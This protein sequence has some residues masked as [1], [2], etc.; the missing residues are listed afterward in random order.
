MDVNARLS[1]HEND[2][3]DF[4]ELL[5]SVLAAIAIVLLVAT[6]AALMLLIK[7]AGIICFVMGIYL[8]YSSFK[9]EGWLA[10]AGLVLLVIG[11]QLWRVE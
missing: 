7:L 11:I 1:I 8:L 4:Y 9:Y 6:S 5:T 2:M 3:K 10:I